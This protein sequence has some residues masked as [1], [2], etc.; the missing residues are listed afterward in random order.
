MSGT[1]IAPQPDKGGSHV[2]LPG[3]IHRLVPPN[4]LEADKFRRRRAG[5]RADIMTSLWGGVHRT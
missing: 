3:L 2:H 4:G 1:G 5:E